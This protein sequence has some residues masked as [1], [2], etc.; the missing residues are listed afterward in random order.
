MSMQN[1]ITII[2]NIA[3]DIAVRK[4]PVRGEER[5][6]ANFGVMVNEGN[7]ASFFPVVAWGKQAENAGKYL[8]KGRGVSLDGYIDSKQREMLDPATKEPRKVYTFSIVATDIL[9]HSKK[10]QT[11]SVNEAAQAAPDGAEMGVE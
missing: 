8:S 10:K 4:V 11:S 7:R 2:G 5:S 3:T 9:Y 6:V 1:K